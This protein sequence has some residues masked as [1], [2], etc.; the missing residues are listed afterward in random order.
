MSHHDVQNFGASLITRQGELIHDL[1][2][3]PLGVPHVLLSRQSIDT[4]WS[5]LL[6]LDEE[7]VTVFVI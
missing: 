6:T 5:D 1:L 4:F 3:V 7:F 2:H